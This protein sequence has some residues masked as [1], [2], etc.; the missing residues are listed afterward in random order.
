MSL[1]FLLRMARLA[2][3]PPSRRRAMLWGLVLAACLALAGLD[4]LGLWPDAL[5]LAPRD[6]VKVHAAP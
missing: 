6:R 1:R 2:R 4:W 3:R 5:T